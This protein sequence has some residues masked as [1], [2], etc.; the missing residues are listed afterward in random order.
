MKGSVLMT[1]PSSEKR[2]RI[3]TIEELA[4]YLRLHK[5]TVYRMVRQGQIPANKIG[6]QWRFRKDVIDSWL[7]EHE[8]G[9]TAKK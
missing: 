5:S 3:M 6:N 9:K 7:S 2:L 1:Q 4:R 8:Y